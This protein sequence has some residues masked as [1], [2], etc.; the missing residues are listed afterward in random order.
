LSFSTFLFFQVSQVLYFSN[1][2][3]CGMLFMGIEFCNFEIC[4]ELYAN[5][6]L[7]FY[8]TFLSL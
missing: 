2:H 3:A 8:E 5:K 4:G 7:K 6:Q 1:I